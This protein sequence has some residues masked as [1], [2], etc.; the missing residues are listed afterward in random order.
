MRS[1]VTLL[2][3][4]AAA[5]AATSPLAAREDAQTCAVSVPVSGLL[6]Y[7]IDK[8]RCALSFPAVPATLAMLPVSALTLHASLSWKRSNLHV[9]LNKVTVHLASNHYYVVISY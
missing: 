6:K 1:F 5:T 3:F 7:S 4:A 8:S 2:A 9:V